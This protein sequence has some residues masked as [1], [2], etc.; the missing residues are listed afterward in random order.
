MTY[1]APQGPLPL[2]PCGVVVTATSNEDN[3]TSGQALVNVHVIVSIAPSPANIG[4][5]GN[6]QFTGSVIGA[7]TTS[8]G[9]SIQWSPQ[10]GGAFDNPV[11]NNGLYVAPPLTS[12]E[13]PITVTIQATS[14]FDQTQT[15]S[16]PITVVKVDPLGTI[17]QSTAA[18]ALITCPD[19]GGIGAA[20]ASC[21][22][23][24]VS[25]DAIADYNVYLKVNAPTGTPF[26]TVILGTGSGG[27][28]L[29]DNDSSFMAGSFNGG[30]NRGRSIEPSNA[31]AGLY[32][33]ASLVWRSLHPQSPATEWLAAGSGRSA[34]FG[35][36]L[37]HCGRLGL[38]E[39]SQL[40]HRCPVLRHGKQC[41]IRRHRVRGEPI[42]TRAR[43]R[44]DRGHKRAGDDT[45]ESGLQRL[46]YPISGGQPL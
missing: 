5:R 28:S 45:A 26:G 38:Q 25:C 31:N 18:S 40:K 14:S 10:N 41:R 6:L 34:P 19:F 16:V 35:V 13:A 1:T 43:V 3:V 29:Y 22:Q 8:A 33:G 17:A 4:Q 44:L 42:R 30:D 12:G 32:H 37:R 23:L 24:K 9:Q 39:H 46:P 36:P 2:S 7:P 11:Y 20:N 21:Y 15:A 27:T